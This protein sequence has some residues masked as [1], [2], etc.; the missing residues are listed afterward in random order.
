LQEAASRGVDA[1]DLSAWKQFVLNQLQSQL[2]TAEGT[3]ATLLARY[4]AGKDLTSRY[5][6]N[7]EAVTADRVNAILKA[8]VSGGRIEYLVP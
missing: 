2:S 4:A 5:K 8:L 6:E 3:V 7:V 1:K